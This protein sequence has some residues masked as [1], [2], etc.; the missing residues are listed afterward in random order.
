MPST[1]ATI[2]LTKQEKIAPYNAIKH[3]SG[4][5]YNTPLNALSA[6]DGIALRGPCHRKA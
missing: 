2:S 5:E 4:F 6:L 3:I 1:Q